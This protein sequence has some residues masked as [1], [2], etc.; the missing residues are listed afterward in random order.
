MFRFL[1]RVWRLFV[2]ESGRLNPAIV[3]KAPTPEF[4]RLFH[5][6]VKKV[7]EDIEG[8]R[9]NTAISQLMIFLNE[10][11]KLQELPRKELE[12]FVTLLSP[13]APHVAEELWELLGHK[14]SLAYEPWPVFDPVKTIEDMVEV[15]LQVNAKVRGKLL[16]AQ[17]TDDKELERLAGK[18]PNTQKYLE[19]KKVLRTIVV[20]NKL[21][22]IVVGS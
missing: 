18:D 1:N 4:E 10:A 8:L 7:G 19:G 22:N 12:Q 16:V 2:D 6:T 11:Y 17:G 5:Q 9:F 15:V 3:E 14:K 21:V 20:K 13:F